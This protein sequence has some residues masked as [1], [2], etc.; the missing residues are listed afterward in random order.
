MISAAISSI[1]A[2]VTPRQQVPCGARRH[3]S[4]SWSQCLALK[5]RRPRCSAL[6]A[7]IALAKDESPTV[8]QMCGGQMWRSG[9]CV[10]DGG[11]VFVGGGGA[12]PGP[13][14]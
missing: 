7:A 8:R 3:N 10:D 2:H 5:H 11:C 12:C 6:Q 14:A 13:V 4:S 1:T 9:L